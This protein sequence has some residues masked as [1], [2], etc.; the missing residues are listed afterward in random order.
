MYHVI[1]TGQFCY[2]LVREWPLSIFHGGGGG[3]LR[4]VCNKNVVLS[5][6]FKQITKKWSGVKQD[7]LK[8]QY[9]THN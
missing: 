3:F 4:G 5:R 6:G 2:G 7:L 8:F 9:V 1:P